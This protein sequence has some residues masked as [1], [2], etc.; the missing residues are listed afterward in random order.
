MPIRPRLLVLLT[1]LIA[2]SAAVTPARS[3]AQAGSG[4]ECARTAPGD[5]H[6]SGAGLP[7]WTDV[8]PYPFGSEGAPVDTSQEQCAHGSSEEAACYLTVASM[9]FRAWNRGLAATVATATA[10]GGERAKTAYGLWIFNGTRWFPDSTFPG[11]SVCK[12]TR[13]VWAGKLDYWLVGGPNWANLCRFDGGSLAWEPLGVPEAT[14]L[15]ATP[16]G[17]TKPA[18]GTIT[19]AACFSWD[20]CWFFGTYGTVVHWDG[21]KLRDR[22]PDRRLRWLAGEYTAALALPDEAGNGFGV[23]VGATDESVTDDAETTPKGVLPAQPDEARPPQMYGS[24]GGPFTRLPFAPVTIPRRPE[25]LYRTDLV[26]LGF[27]AAGQGWVAGNPAGVRTE[28]SVGSDPQLPAGRFLSRAPQPSPLEPVSAAG[29]TSSCE[30][31]PEGRFMYSGDPKE[32]ETAGALL[33]GSL[34]VIPSSGEALAGGRMRRAQA[35][36]GRDEDAIGEPVIVRADCHGG[37]EVTRFRITDPTEPTSE[38]AADRGGTVT[39]LVANA[40]NDA[41]AATTNGF[42]KP[43]IE[44]APPFQPPHLYRLT[45]GQPPAAPEGDDLEARPLELREDK[46][47]YV[48]E[49]PVEAPPPPAPPIITRSTTVTLSPA[50]YGVKVRLHKSK[51]NGHEHLSLYLTFKLRRPVTL[52]AQALRHGRVVSVARPRLFKGHTGTLV[53]NLDRNRWPTKVGFIT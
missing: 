21:E 30:G 31:P 9:A 41:W 43:A 26:A 48:L 11:Q 38:T 22:S 2:A 12:G 17:G 20:D 24:S 36:A 15:R 18:P 39:A 6:G 50:V 29:A 28:L 27:D 45:D 42:L 7:C 49:P 47:I 5:S 16:P 25:D 13:V 8:K 33:W 19:S 44:V 10:A 37:T 52:G 23:A 40:T 53:L 32:T 46:P 1:A 14:L 51:R 3:S 35:G 34:A 4:P